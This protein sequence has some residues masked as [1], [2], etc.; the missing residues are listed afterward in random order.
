MAMNVLHQR[1]CSSASWANMVREDLLPWALAG[2]DLGEQTLEI[3]PGYGA[4]LRALVDRAGAVTAVE[5]DE[6][7]AERL[8]HLYGDRARVLHGDGSDT[9]LPDKA[10]DSVVCFTMLHHVP[11]DQLQDRLFA[12]AFRV[13]R[14]GGVFAGSD[15]L[16][17]LL[18]RLIHLRDTYNPVEPDGLRQRLGRIGFDD[19]RID[20]A[21]T[22]LRW[23]AAKP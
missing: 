21:G 20:T 7:M 10:F 2:V 13:L 22:R 11:T 12:E 19:I 9:G 23:R 17:S 1:R 14:P 4:T 16:G 18:F 8:N 5:V 6:P 15:R 3:G